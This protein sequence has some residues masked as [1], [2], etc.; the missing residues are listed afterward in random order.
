MPKFILTAKDKSGRTFNEIIEAFDSN[1]AVAQIQAK[2]LFVT[3]VKQVADAAPSIQKKVSSNNSA[4]RFTHSKATLEDIISFSRQM[5]TMLSAGVPLMRSISVISEQVESKQLSEVLHEL[6]SDVSEG[7]AF[8]RALTKHPKVFSPFWVSLVEVGEA[9]GTMPAVLEKLTEYME[10]AAA[11]KSAVVGALVYPAVLF[12]VC[13]GAVVAFAVFIGP[14]FERIFKD[15]GMQLPG[16]TSAVLAMF[17]IIRTQ[18]LFIIGAGI[19]GWFMFKGYIKTDIGRRNF[20]SFLFR[21]PV[22]GKIFK[23]I[24][25]EKFTSQ[26][27]MLVDSGVPILYALEISERLVDNLVCAEVIKGVREAVREGRLLADPMET[28]GFF[29]PMAVQMIRVGEETGELGKMLNHVA[30]YYKRNVKDFLKSFGT[31]IEP[32]MLI[33]MGGIIGVLII[34]MFLPIL[35]MSTGG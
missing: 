28:S 33:V 35:T 30:I 9:S 8:S 10:E 23:L 13:T 21:M 34:A 24:I 25:V 3:S 16:I 29:P 5:A 22:F 19:G 6:V 17:K 1:A 26:M 4:G 20:E 15:M 12:F 2:D 18:F 32:V 31:L 7:Q 11:F 27:A 14:T